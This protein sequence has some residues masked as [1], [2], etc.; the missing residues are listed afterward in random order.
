MR[1][2]AAEKLEAIR[3]VEGSEL[4]VRTTLRQLGLAPSTF[5][6]WYARYAEQGVEG[7]EDRKPRVRRF[8]NV[9]PDRVRE[10]V[11]EMALD[12][13]EL[14]PR[15]LA[16]RFTDQHR[17]FLSESSVYRILKAHDLIT[18][19]AYL[20]MSASDSFRHPTTRVHE[21]WQ[22]D[23]TYLRVIG[24]GWYYLSTVMD[25]FSRYIIAYKLSA[26][27]GAA[28]VTETL[29]RA[30]AVTGVASVK[31]RHRP[32]LLSDNG[33]AYVSGELRE[34]LAGRGMAHT[35]GAPYHPQTQGKIERFH[36]SMKNVVKL[37]HYYFPWQLEAAVRD[38]VVYYNNERFHESLN[39]VTPADVY[40]GRQHAVLSKRQRI[41]RLTLQR[42]RRENQ[43]QEAA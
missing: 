19:P 1:R 20:L 10:Q 37:E 3:L 26:T 7:L 25:D 5:Y 22:T 41:K 36:R 18:S 39:N 6:D 9:I 12:R 23:F 31:V 16:C 8:W 24:W 27:M 28:D 35:R 2:N 21:M 42:R 33:P 30:L 17:Y 29:D 43:I 40:F 14:S 32:R 13:T 11:V 15:E 4:P 38:F 34:Y